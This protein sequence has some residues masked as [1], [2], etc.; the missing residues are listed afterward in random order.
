MAHD[1]PSQGAGLASPPTTPIRTMENQ[2]MSTSKVHEGMAKS[3][4]PSAETENV[5]VNVRYTLDCTYRDG[6]DFKVS[7]NDKPLDIQ[8]QKEEKT[9]LPVIEIITEI[10][11]VDMAMGEE[12]KKSHGDVSSTLDNKR[13]K[14]VGQE[15]LQIHS[16]VLSGLLRNLVQYYPGQVFF[17]FL[18]T[19]SPRSIVILVEIPMITK[20]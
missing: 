14:R 13:V 5:T 12:D 8:V 6:P 18:S 2:A 4:A 15:L 19:P 20:L 11:V 9:I 3:V 1:L 16:P 7:Q 17:F 10:T